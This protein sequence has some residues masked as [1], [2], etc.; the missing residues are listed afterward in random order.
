MGKS[1]KINF[2]FNLI[3]TVTS[4]LFPLITFPYVSRILLPEGIGISK[5]LSVNHT[6]YRIVFQ[7][8]NTN[9]CH[10]GNSEVQG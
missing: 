9:V 4:L 5:F 7:L 2:I 10:K 8:G 1:I 6:V 3:N